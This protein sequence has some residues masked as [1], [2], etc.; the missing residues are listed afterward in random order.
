MILTRVLDP[1]GFYLDPDPLVE[2]K[3]GSGSNFREKTDLVPT[4]EQKQDL[5]LDS[6]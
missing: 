5:D 2:K 4:F 3:N 6:T 1:V